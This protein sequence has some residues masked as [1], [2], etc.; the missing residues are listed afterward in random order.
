MTELSHMSRD[1][2]NNADGEYNGKLF[3]GGM[4]ATGWS[5]A[6]KRRSCLP[7]GLN[8]SVQAQQL[9]LQRRY[10]EIRVKRLRDRVDLTR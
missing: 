10:Y 9:Q 6:I 1:K 8:Y 4:C 7:T 3:F 2:H 5:N